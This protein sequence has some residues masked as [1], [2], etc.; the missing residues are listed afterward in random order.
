[1]PSSRPTSTTSSCCSGPAHTTG[2]TARPSSK[3]SSSP[4]TAGNHDTE[5]VRLFHQRNLR[6]HMLLGPANS[7]MTHHH[8]IQKF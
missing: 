1:M 5:L 6:S 4:D 2:E 3:P 7:A 8:T